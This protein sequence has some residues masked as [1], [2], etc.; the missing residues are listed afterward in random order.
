MIFQQ[1]QIR[2]LF[3]YAAILFRKQHYVSSQHR[4]NMELLCKVGSWGNHVSSHPVIINGSIEHC[5]WVCI[6]SGT[7]EL[8]DLEDRTSDLDGRK[9]MDTWILTR[10]ES[11]KWDGTDG[12]KLCDVSTL[13][14]IYDYSATGTHKHWEMTRMKL[15]V[16][17][18]VTRRVQR[19][20]NVKG[21]LNT[22]RLHRVHSEFI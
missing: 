20:G 22:I 11:H 18:T 21:S 8:N 1:H 12:S 15:K 2:Y 17:F 19:S 13:V 10:A 14:W 9:A 7:M 5:S 16:L 6:V 3:R 4:A